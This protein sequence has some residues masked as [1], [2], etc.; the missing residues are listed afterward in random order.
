M[1]YPLHAKLQR[2]AKIE[3]YLITR[4]HRKGITGVPIIHSRIFANKIYLKV[5][6]HYRD[7]NDYF[8]TCQPKSWLSIIHNKIRLRSSRFRASHFS[9]KKT[10][11]YYRN[12]LLNKKCIFPDWEE[13]SLSF[14]SQNFC[15]NFIFVWR[16]KSFY[17]TGQG[18]LYDVICW[19]LKLFE[20]S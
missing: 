14:F 3:S 1:A 6:L 11:I 17:G 4:Q 9:K 10:V 2:Y 7:A 16:K 20:M 13:L 18:I 8:P 15:K 5:S 12:L 19:S